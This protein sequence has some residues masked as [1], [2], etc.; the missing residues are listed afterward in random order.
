MLS[1]H[2]KPERKTKFT[3]EMVRSKGVWVGVNTLLT[4]DLAARIIEEGLIDDPFWK[5]LSIVR[6]EAAYEDSRLDFLLSSGREEIYT[7]V[8]SVTLKRKDSARFPD[9]VTVRGKKHTNALAELV[10]KGFGAAVLFLVQ[11]S[12]CDSFSPAGD[13]DPD[14]TNALKE[15]LDSGVQSA[16]C[17]LDVNPE[18]I[19]F[20]GPVPISV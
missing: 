15:A 10:D 17:R 6:R 9:S 7:E 5:N 2:D 18:R 13:I 12:D 11:R 8:K 3:L 14:Y 19:E 16:A 4:N 20:M 1:A